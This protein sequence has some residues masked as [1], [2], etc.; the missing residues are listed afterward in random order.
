M[1]SKLD[2]A[3]GALE[4][5]AADSFADPFFCDEGLGRG[6]SGGRGIKMGRGWFE[7]IFHSVAQSSVAIYCDE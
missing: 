1:A 6:S 3:H 4:A 5:Q 2:Q 7:L